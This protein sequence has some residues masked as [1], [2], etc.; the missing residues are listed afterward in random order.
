MTRRRSIVLFLLLSVLV[1]P[2]RAVLAADITGKWTAS[3]DTQIG[4]QN[5]TYDFVVKDTTL[6]GKAKSNLGEGE[7]LDGKV[8]G[9]KVTFTEILKF[10]GMEI[11][12]TYTG[13]VVNADEIKFTRQVGDFA[14]EE[15]VAKRAK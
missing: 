9:D 11:R 13:T 8:D 2:G 4:Q 5:Y 15:L 10:E 7:V 3:F 12:I 1:V 14:T 6:T